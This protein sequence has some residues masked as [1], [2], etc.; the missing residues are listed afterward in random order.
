M[1][2]VKFLR[3]VNG[4]ARPIRLQD[5]LA[6]G[7]VFLSIAVTCALSITAAI[8]SAS[9]RVT[10]FAAASLKG[11]LDDIA[12]VAPVEVVF[13]YAG[14]GLIARQVAQGAPA[15]VVILANR[16]WM[17]WLVS[18]LPDN[19]MSPI[20]L[21]GNRLVLIGQADADEI[22]DMSEVT[23]L[24]RL[25][26]G[27]LAIGLTTSVPAGIYARQWLEAKGM[28]EAL[29]PHLAEVDNV[30]A[31]VALVARGEV[32]LA[33][34]YASDAFAEPNIRVV[35][36][37]P[38]DAHDPITYTALTLHG[39]SASQADEFMN[40]LKGDEAQAIFARHG[41]LAAEARP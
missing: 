23:L 41:F 35:Y 12:A 19:D 34:A 39:K 9:D 32:L 13:S 8:A 28:W 26:G 5:T 14:S 7:R 16:S 21:L 38:A 20:D 27:R 25:E 31:A 3:F 15:D 40:F 36:E 17:D 29:R 1:N 4:L 22:K 30:R 24:R 33:V 11:A 10:V 6:M 18:S 2:L 37:I